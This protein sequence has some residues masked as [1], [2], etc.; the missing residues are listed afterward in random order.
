MNT[1]ATATP[2]QAQELLRIVGDPAVVAR[3]MARFRRAAKAFSSNHPRLIDRYPEQ[4]V[5]AY[6]DQIMADPSL[7]ALLAR[8]DTAGIPR[9][10]AIIRF[11]TRKQ[12]VLI[13]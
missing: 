13:L 1:R 5:A 12:R 6:D 8:M 3:D 7:E 4:W 9:H 2:E 11:I 10:Q